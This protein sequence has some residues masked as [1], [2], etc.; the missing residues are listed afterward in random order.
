VTE[1]RRA[2]QAY[3]VEA[4]AAT[5]PVLTSITEADLDRP[6]YSQ[7]E[8]PWL[9]RDVVAHLA[10]AESGLLGQARRLMAGEQTVPENFDLD[11]WNRGAVRRNRTRSLPDLLEQIQSSHMEAVATVLS[12]EEASLDLR[13][14]HSSGA[15]LTGEGFFRRMAD[16]RREH[17]RD[18]A[19]ALGRTPGG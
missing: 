18:L 6:V 3:L 5:W 7:S 11:R 10:D 2:I 8:G 19:S 12:A 15:I 17:T 1:R 14:R 13:G 16:H 9:V 4:H